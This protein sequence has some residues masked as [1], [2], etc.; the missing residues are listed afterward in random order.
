MYCTVFL[1]CFRWFFIFPSIFITNDFIMGEFL[2]DRTQF[3][4]DVC[5]T[6]SW[7]IITSI[8]LRYRNIHGVVGDAK[9]NDSIVREV[10]LWNLKNKF[11]SM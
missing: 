3:A 9:R 11:S 2:L 10:T 5:G 6:L 1:I 4:I 7:L 8:G